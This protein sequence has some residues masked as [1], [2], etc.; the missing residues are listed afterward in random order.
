MTT[1]FHSRACKGSNTL[2][3][4]RLGLSESRLASWHGSQ[5]PKA[6]F[7]RPQVESTQIPL[8]A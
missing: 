8:T 5:Y 4:A 6:T 3:A 2:A 1:M 7:D